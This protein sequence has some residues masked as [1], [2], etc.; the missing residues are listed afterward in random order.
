VSDPEPSR[1]RPT[2][3]EFASMVTHELRN[4]LNALAGWLH[5]IGADPA[6]KS[7]LGERAV[8][9]ARRAIEQQLAQVDMLG[10]LL[11]LSG[12]ALPQARESLD[13]GR[14]V[15]TEAHAAASEGSS[16][17]QQGP[18]AGVQGTMGDAVRLNGWPADG[19]PSIVGDGSL[20]APAVRS[21]VAFALR[22]GMPG[23][24]LDLSLSAGASDRA[25]VVLRV[26]EGP[27]PGLSIWHA[28]GQS[29][30]RLS[31]DLYLA[32]LVI[33]AHGG[34]VRPRPAAEGGE[35]LEIMLPFRRA[36]DG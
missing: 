11:R 27:D 10:I 30:S 2:V 35:E 24:P 36:T 6:M 9:G 16:V 12:G 25:V 22:H 14:L 17:G 4:P 32:T 23:A 31:L 1:R 34:T 7:G 29:G 28:F 33:E 8:A 21:L 15:R 13:L 3:D 20:L 18:D 5:L 19:G 26:N